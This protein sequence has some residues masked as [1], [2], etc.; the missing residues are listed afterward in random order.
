MTDDIDIEELDD[1]T[2]ETEIHHSNETGDA[3]DSSV[4]HVN[5]LSSANSPL[6]QQLQKNIQAAFGSA[7][8]SFGGMYTDA[9]I[10]KMESDVEM[11]E[12]EVNCR[13]ADVSNWETKVSLNDTIE[14]RKNGDYAYAV[15]QLQNAQSQYS[16]A[17]ERYNQ[18]MSRLNNAR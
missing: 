3:N 18:A 1:D 2:W 13:R 15:S 12:Y 16:Y 10:D 5:A 11:A 14:D 8:P 9:E 17:L 7:H 4:S 6:V